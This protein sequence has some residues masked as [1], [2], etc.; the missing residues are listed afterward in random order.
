MLHICICKVAPKPTFGNKIA[1]DL[2]EGFRLRV[3]GHE[4]VDEEE[5]ADTRGQFRG[6]DPTGQDF[7]HKSV[8]AGSG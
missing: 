3:A 8:T 6:P 7:H 5:V 4:G 2:R 1:N